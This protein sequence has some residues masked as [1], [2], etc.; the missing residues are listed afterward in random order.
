MV[1][2]L[3]FLV[4]E[5]K[6]GNFSLDQIARYAAKI[7]VILKALHFN[8]EIQCCFAPKKGSKWGAKNDISF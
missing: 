3:V 6:E 5:E 4:E 7:L 1:L 8:R 2:T